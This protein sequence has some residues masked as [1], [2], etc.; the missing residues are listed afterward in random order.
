MLEKLSVEFIR[1]LLLVSTYMCRCASVFALKRV[2]EYMCALV[3]VGARQSPANT[4]A[5][6][7]RV[8]VQRCREDTSKRVQPERSLRAC[9]AS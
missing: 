9:L 8:S 4:A 3:S 1:F 7:R 2:C 6:V 5:T